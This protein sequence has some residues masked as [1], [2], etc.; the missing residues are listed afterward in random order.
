MSNKNLTGPILTLVLGLLLGGVG[1]Y[2]F[3]TQ[4]G[5]RI[6]EEPPATVVEAATAPPESA[7]SDSA[8]A[9]QFRFARTPGTTESGYPLPMSGRPITMTPVIETTSAPED[10]RYAEYYVPGAETLAEGEMRVTSCGSGGP[11]PL[12]IGQAASCLLVELGNGQVFVFDVG[13]GAVGNLFALGVHP[14][15]L[16]KLFVT[17]LHLDHVG[18]IFPLFDAMG[19]ARNTPLHVWG[20]SGYTPD[21]GIASFVEHVRAA[22]EWHIQSKQDLLP[23]SGMI[24]EA[25]EVDIASFSPSEP[26]QLVYDESGVKIYA[27]PVVHTIAG[28]MGYRL[29]WNGLTFVY[30]ADSEASR[31]E[32]EQARGA[33]VFIHEIFP[34]AEE[35]GARNHMPL[36]HAQNAMSAHTM[37]A[38]LGMVFEIAQPRLGAGMHFTLDDELIDPLFEELRTTFEGP[39]LLMQ[40]MTTINVT[41]EFIVVRQTRPELLAWPD[42]PPSDVEGVS[43]PG[44]RSA[45]QRPDWLT[46]TR[47]QAPQ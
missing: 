34:H 41:P 2:L 29:E 40:D 31:F 6:A 33:D 47:I 7:N 43:P 27:F 18:G 11:A 9:G 25:H 22:S 32:A 24:L 46:E 35:F 16:D 45:A 37:A 15:R 28:A 12:R 5:Q 26:R 4:G 14:A 17:H 21:L 30:T 20:P 44:E 10:G 23:T 1:G 19:W 3:T 36:Q 42:P 8:E 13:G 39:A 38:E